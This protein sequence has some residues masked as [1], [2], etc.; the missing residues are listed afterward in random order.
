LTAT[1]PVDSDRAGALDSDRA[2]CQSAAREI[3]INRR[4]SLH[5]DLERTAG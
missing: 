1:G 4:F 3:T 2:I 5:S